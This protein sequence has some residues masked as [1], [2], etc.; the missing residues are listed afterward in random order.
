MAIKKD[1]QKVAQQI[2]MESSQMHQNKKY[3]MISIFLAVS[4]AIAPLAGAVS[5]VWDPNTDQVDGYNVYYGTSKTSLAQ[6]RDVGMDT[7]LNLDTLNLTEKVQ[8]FFSVSA[9]NAAGERPKTQP[10][11]YIPADTTPPM[12]PTGLEV[13]P[14]GY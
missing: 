4:V 6:K 2:R 11:G 3:L 5:F 13:V 9:Y 12:P 7:R 14:L 1:Y 8:Y 10:L